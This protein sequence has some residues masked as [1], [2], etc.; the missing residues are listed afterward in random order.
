MAQVDA[1]LEIGV[2][3]GHVVRSDQVVDTPA[4]ATDRGHNVVSRPHL[5]YVRSHGLDLAEAFVAD[6]Q[7]F[8]SRRR[9][10]ILGRVDLFVRPVD[11]DT[12]NLDEDA[13]TPGDL[14]D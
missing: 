1:A 11:T 14:V 10:A 8:E 3:R 9:G 4:G 5:R 2:V 6:D 13:A 12:Q 7:E